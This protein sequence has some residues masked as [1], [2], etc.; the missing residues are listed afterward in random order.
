MEYNFVS[1]FNVK[2]TNKKH[3]FGS[4][5]VIGYISALSFVGNSFP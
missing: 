5:F 3:L 4:V 1:R 2:K